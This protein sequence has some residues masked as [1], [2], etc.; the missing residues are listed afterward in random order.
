MSMG[1]SVGLWHDSSLKV[2]RKVGSTL[3]RPFINYKV[4]S[5]LVTSTL[6]QEKGIM[7]VFPLFR[8]I[9]ML[10]KGMRTVLT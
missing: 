4:Q 3:L 8:I 1:R 7:L 5:V 10:A 2:A 9:I 6:S